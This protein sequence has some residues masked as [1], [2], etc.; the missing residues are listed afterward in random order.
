[1]RDSRS[2]PL[3]YRMRVL[4]HSPQRMAL[5]EENVSPVRA[6]GL[7][8]FQ[9]A[10]LQT[11]VFARR[12]T[13]DVWGL[14]ILARIDRQASSLI[15]SGHE[16]STA[17]RALAVF[18]YLAGRGYGIP[19]SDYEQFAL[20]GRIGRCALQPFTNSHATDQPLDWRFGAECA[21]GSSRCAARPLRA[22]TCGRFQG[23]HSYLNRRD[24]GRSAALRKR[25]AFDIEHVEGPGIAWTSQG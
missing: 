11:V 13:N 18:R 12:Q 24:A 3:V 20:T 8:L 14:Y 19:T 21:E 15:V 16:A 23:F 4:E 7:T 6:F 9:P 1:M 10:V 5:A 25:T 2:G 17:N 22:V